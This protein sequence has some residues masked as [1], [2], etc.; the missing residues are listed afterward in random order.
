ME[1]E[2]LAEVLV[3][4]YNT[5]IERENQKHSTN[6][7]DEKY[8]NAKIK[9][10]QNIFEESQVL[11]N[12]F[13]NSLEFTVSLLGSYPNRLKEAIEKRGNCK[14]AIERGQI[15]GQIVMLNELIETV[16]EV[17]SEMAKESA[18]NS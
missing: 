12:K 16:K 15:N 1:K 2:K 11:L 3:S 7:L 13:D 10:M 17:S 5:L 9:S 14:N 6:V 4:N 18:S 8:K